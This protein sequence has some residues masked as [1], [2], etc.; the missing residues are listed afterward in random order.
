M[1]NEVIEIIREK[2]S[3]GKTIIV[4]IDGA[5]GSGKSTISEIIAGS[6]NNENIGTVVYHIDDFIHPRAVR[7]NDVYPQ[8]EQYYYLQWRYDHFIDKVIT[9]VRNGASCCEAELYDKEND[10]YKVS[11]TDISDVKAVIVEGVFL[12][13]K[14]LSGLFDYM[15]YLDVPKETR[16][17]RVLKR[18]G[19][20]GDSSDIL[21]KYN[22][23]YFPAEDFYEN[24]YHP[25]EIADHVI[26]V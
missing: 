25:S 23:R 1:Y 2:V 22:E 17:E 16:L 8:W 7:Y 10:S 21:K 3:N 12:Q 20:I 9:P 13:R 15:I 19:Y 24:E 5:G 26:K 4:G 18:D 11:C 14:E 6:L